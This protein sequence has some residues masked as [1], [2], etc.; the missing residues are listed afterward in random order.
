M[1]IQHIIPVSLLAAVLSLSA[2]ARAEDSAIYKSVGPNGVV[3]YTNSPQGLKNAAK[4]S[5][6]EAP[7]SGGVG[8]NRETSENAAALAPAPA[9]ASKNDPKADEKN[10]SYAAAQAELDRA[11]KAQATGQ[12]PKEGERTGTAN[13][14]SRLNSAYFERQKNLADAVTSAKAKLAQA[15]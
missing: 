4:I 6:P 15:Q 1:K 2:S 8:Q 11:L 9:P 3:T 14:N 10:Q 13:G 12:E 7:I 5:L